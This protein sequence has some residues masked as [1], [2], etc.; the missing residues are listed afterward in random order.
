MRSLVAFW[1]AHRAELIAEGLVVHRLHRHEV[2]LADEQVAVRID[3]QI[4]GRLQQRLGAS[5][6][7]PCDREWE[8]ALGIGRLNRL[9]LVQD[10]EAHDRDEHNGDHAQQ[11]G[12][13]K[14]RLAPMDARLEVPRRVQCRHLASEVLQAL[15]EVSRH[16]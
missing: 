14:T 11:P 3:H 9:G 2:Q 1:I 16:G 12:C 8:P 15:A 10:T 4:L 13:D 5:L 6:R 7:C